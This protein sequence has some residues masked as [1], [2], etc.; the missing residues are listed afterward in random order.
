MRVIATQRCFIDNKLREAGEE[1]D[2]DGLIGPRGIDP[3]VRK[4]EEG[5][6]AAPAVEPPKRRGRSRKGEPAPVWTTEGHPD[7]KQSDS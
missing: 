3:L 6:A 1:F 7:S 2:Y 4:G 5:L